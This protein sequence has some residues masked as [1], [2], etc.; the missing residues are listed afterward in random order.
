MFSGNQI[1]TNIKLF[2]KK[3]FESLVNKKKKKKKKKNIP[4][5]TVS[6]IP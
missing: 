4:E 1:N 5:A 2:W 6:D 3:Y